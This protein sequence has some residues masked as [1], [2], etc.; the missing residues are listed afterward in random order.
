MGRF[1]FFSTRIPEEF[2]HLGQDPD[3]LDNLIQNPRFS[4][5]I[6]V[7]RKRLEACMAETGDPALEAFR[8]R[9]N[10]DE[11]ARFMQ[12]QRKKSGKR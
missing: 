8:H 10:P 11:I 5:E 3:A 9:E 6:E 7:F 12:E 1:G 2:Y 4:D